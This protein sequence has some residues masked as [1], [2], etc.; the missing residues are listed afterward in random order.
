MKILVMLFVFGIS[1]VIYSQSFY[2]EDKSVS[3]FGIGSS[4]S[5]NEEYST[6][7]IRGIWAAYRYLD[8][9]I[10]Y[11]KR[12][13]ETIEFS[14]N[15]LNTSVIIYP[16]R[17][18]PSYPISAHFSVGYIVID[19]QSKLLKDYGLESLETYF[20][21]GAEVFVEYAL[22]E[23]IKIVPSVKM[24]RHTGVLEIRE[25]NK[26]GLRKEKGINIIHIKVAIATHDIG[27]TFFVAPG[28]L[29]NNEESVFIVTTGV[30]F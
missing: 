26:T 14:K 3:S 20:L 24:E 27:S 29:I 5:V 28:V 25:E 15:Y 7:G 8:M 12:S 16:L 9:E 30:M 23:L 10:E 19:N 17:L 4:F 18:L 21:F 11:G 2:Q 6:I 13:Y 1:S 22:S